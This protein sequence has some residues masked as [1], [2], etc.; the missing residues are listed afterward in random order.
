M[1]EREAGVNE[2][3]PID[4]WLT[5]S[6][7]SDLLALNCWEDRW[8]GN[9]QIIPKYMPPYPGEHT[10]PS[11]QIRYGTSYLRWS[12]GPKQGQKLTSRT[13]TCDRLCLCFR[14][15]SCVSLSIFSGSL[16]R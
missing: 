4:Q 14:Q 1:A 6:K 7:I 8:R 10:R 15:Y 12:Q 16:V 9:C 13:H 11:V 3:L 2:P 5:N